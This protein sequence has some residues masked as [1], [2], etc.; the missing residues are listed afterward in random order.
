MALQIY[1]AD[2]LRIDWKFLGK[3]SLSENPFCVSCLMLLYDAMYFKLV[4]NLVETRFCMTAQIM[5]FECCA[6][7]GPEEEAKLL[8]RELSFF[9]QSSRQTMYMRSVYMAVHR[10]IGEV[11]LYFIAQSSLVL[12][13]FY[14]LNA[15]SGEKTMIDVIFSRWAV[16]VMISF[17]SQDGEAG[18]K[19][20]EQFWSYLLRQY[21]AT[22]P[23][24][25]VFNT[26]HHSGSLPGI[27]YGVIWRLRQGMC[28]MVNLVFR[29]IIIGTAPIW[30]ATS[31]PLDFV[32]DCMAIFFVIAL[33]DL[34]PREFWTE[35]FKVYQREQKIEA[36]YKYYQK[37]T[38]TPTDAINPPS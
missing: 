23:W 8:T 22:E 29:N 36:A 31:E 19:Y 10:S 11:F 15:L 6:L 12:Y 16:A 32:K 18:A 33:D 24:L 25:N 13:Y 4:S 9:P 20:D 37:Q 14:E 17:I 34:D 21:P 28:L 1:F 30:L 2:M 3:F 27:T 7:G 38:V 35:L 5:N 26:T